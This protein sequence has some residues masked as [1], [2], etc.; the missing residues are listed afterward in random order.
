MGYS[1]AMTAALDPN[2]PFRI[3]RPTRAHALALARALFVRGDRLD[4]QSLAGQLGIGRTTLYR[5]VGDRDQLLGSVLAQLAGE[6]AQLVAEQADGDGL[7][8]ALDTIRRF[9][10]VTSSFPPLIEF[11]QREPEVA[12]RVLLA[13]HSAVTQQLRLF[14]RTALDANLAPPVADDELVEVITQLAT[15]LEW[16]PIIVG[17]PP[18][19]D[20]AIRLMRSVLAER[21]HDRR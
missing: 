8:R 18:A 19:I 5:W 14:F 15:A 17:E 7:D 20:R 16:S 3:A 10:T 6:T 1:A 9:M 21:P 2:A 11:A 4:M 12:L 13:Q